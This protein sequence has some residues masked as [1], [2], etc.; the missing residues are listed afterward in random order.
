MTV[1]RNAREALKPDNSNT[2][3]CCFRVLGSTRYKGLRAYRA[4]SLG[5]GGK[6]LGL[7]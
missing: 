1:T 3:V 6:V 2:R 4:Q 7:G 5:F